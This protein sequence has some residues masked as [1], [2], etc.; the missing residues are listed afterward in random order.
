MLRMEAIS[1]LSAL[2]LFKP[3]ASWA[4]GHTFCEFLWSMFPV[5]EIVCG[6]DS[7][8]DNLQRRIIHFSLMEAKGL[9]WQED[10]FL[11]K[12]HYFPVENLILSRLLSAPDNPYVFLNPISKVS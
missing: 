12:C 1:L 7:P 3:C 9:M 10:P 8:W 4:I 6:P 5:C 11:C 2:C